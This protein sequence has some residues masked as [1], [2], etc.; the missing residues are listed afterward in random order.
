MED[1]KFMTREIIDRKQLFILL[2]QLPLLIQDIIYAKVRESIKKYAR[3]HVF[4]KLQ[5]PFIYRL[6]DGIAVMAH[7][8]NPYIP[9]FN[10][11]MWDTNICPRQD[12]VDKYNMVNSNTINAI[13][14]IYYDNDYSYMYREFAINCIMP[15]LHKYNYNPKST[16]KNKLGNNTNNVRDKFENDSE[17]HYKDEI[18][19]ILQINKKWDIHRKYQGYNFNFN[20]SGIEYINMIDKNTL[21]YANTIYYCIISPYLRHNISMNNHNITINDKLA[22]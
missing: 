13:F 19:P 7:H 10:N 9:D 22:N 16:N 11:T 8:L 17:Y 20:V 1:N 12:L 5:R 4:P 14:L 6:I 2:K 21:M 15:H 3:A 18:H